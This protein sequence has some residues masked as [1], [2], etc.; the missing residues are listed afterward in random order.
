MAKMHIKA[1]FL[2]ERCEVCHQADRFDA[3]RNWCGRCAEAR[4]TNILPFPADLYR[5]GRLGWLS[6]S[7]CWMGL[8]KWRYLRWDR[9]CERCATIQHVWRV[10]S[11]SIEWRDELDKNDPAFSQEAMMLPLR[12]WRCLYCFRVVMSV[13]PPGYFEPCPYCG[14]T[15]YVGRKRNLAG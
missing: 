1:E 3:K 8:H 4:S 9:Y 13:H 12:E 6:R 10:L 2:P 5:T 15:D 7:L 14:K 11:S